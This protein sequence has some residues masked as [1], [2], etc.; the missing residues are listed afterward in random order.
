MALIAS[1]I[2]RTTSAAGASSA[3]SIGNPSVQAR[4][5]PA[6]FRC[7]ARNLVS[8]SRSAAGPSAMT[9]TNCSNIGLIVSAASCES[10]VISSSLSEKYR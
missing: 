8:Q 9:S 10:V 5:T 4:I 7:A 2:D 1:D 6:Y 3:G